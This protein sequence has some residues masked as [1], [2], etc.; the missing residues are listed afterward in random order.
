MVI[1]PRRL[2]EWVE[3]IWRRKRVL[4]LMALV[5]MIAAYVIIRRLPAVYESKAQIVVTHYPQGTDDP[6]GEAASFSAVIAHLTSRGNL[7]GLIQRHKLYSDVKKFDLAIDLLG[8]AIKPVVTRRPYGYPEVP[9]AVTISFRYP[10]AAIAQKVVID[11]VSNFERANESVRQRASGELATLKGTIDGVE[12]RLQELGP[13]RDLEVI[14]AQM[15]TRMATEAAANRSQRM[16]VGTMIESLT[17]R[18]YTLERQIAE[19]KSQIAEQ[20]K[21][22]SS[23]TSNG[24]P[25]TNPA[26]GALIVRRAELTARIK[27]YTEEYTE[28]NPKLIDAR[29]QLAQINTELQKLEAGVSSGAVAYSSPE[30]TELKRMELELNRY[31]TDLDVTRRDLARKSKTMETIPAG[32]GSEQPLLT[33]G[34]DPS[35]AAGAAGVSSDTKTEQERLQE[36][37]KALLGKQDYLQKLAGIADSTAPMFQILDPP[38]MPVVPVAPNRRMLFVF[39]SVFAV[40][41]GLVIILILELPRFFIFSDER[42]I[43]YF[44]GAP[45]LALIPETI[46]HSERGRHR[47]LRWT[48]N[49]VLLLFAAAIIPFLIVLIDRMG[50][51]QILGSR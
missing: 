5:M 29:A 34:V 21:I 33:P 1:R 27:S 17:D 50:V 30:A 10:D 36:R 11:L 37:Y 19:L 49:L 16:T 18:E 8:K 40:G 43:Q 48:R 46:S 3:I 4:F 12:K 44:L 13:V 24:V 41:F 14:R 9:E 38:N 7:A 42:D 35:G 45:V 31:Q 15:A 25:T 28:K 39:A 20:R 22:V 6:V 26:V 32:T 51:F 23:S 2:F 47:R